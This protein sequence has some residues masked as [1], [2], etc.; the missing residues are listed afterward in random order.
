[1]ATRILL[2]RAPL[3]LNGRHYGPAFPSLRLPGMTSLLFSLLSCCQLLWFSPLRSPNVSAV[4]R[5]LLLFLFLLRHLVLIFTCILRLNTGTLLVP[6]GQ[7]ET[8]QPIRSVIPT[9][10]SPNSG[11]GRPPAG[12][13]PGTL[14]AAVPHHPVSNYPAKSL[15]SRD[16]RVGE[17]TLFAPPFF[18]IF[19]PVLTLPLLAN[20]RFTARFE[21]LEKRRVPQDRVVAEL[22]Y[23]LTSITSLQSANQGEVRNLPQ[24]QTPRLAGSLLS[25]FLTLA[26]GLKQDY[27]FARGRDL[28]WQDFVKR[29]KHASVSHP[30][31]TL[32]RIHCIKNEIPE[33]FNG[34]YYLCVCVCVRAL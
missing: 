9:E 20:R 26:A 16:S 21:D 6:K 11:Q 19:S 8:C 14:A 2:N 1:M 25:R 5:L 15:P 33:A 17:V 23:L 29:D 18:A 4:N 7:A 22:D 12:P 32:I 10:I 13:S 27:F 31:N 28:F 3:L 30:A 34:T 24:S